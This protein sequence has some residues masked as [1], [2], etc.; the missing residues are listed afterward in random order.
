M[1]NAGRA[2]SLNFEAWRLNIPWGLDFGVL[3]VR[4]TRHPAL[5]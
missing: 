5:K 4:N 1:E 2:F 3:A